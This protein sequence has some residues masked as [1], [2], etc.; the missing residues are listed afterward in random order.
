LGQTQN[1]PIAG[2]KPPIDGPRPIAYGCAGG[3][4]FSVVYKKGEEADLVMGTKTFTLKQVLSGSGFKYTDN[5]LTLTGKGQ[6]AM[7]EGAT[8][9]ALR[10]C[11]AKDK[12]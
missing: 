4:T 6:E 1:P 5:T 8:G 11:I 3:Q 2:E 7:L 9:G 10:D 12:L